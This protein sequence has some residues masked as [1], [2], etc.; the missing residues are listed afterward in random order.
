M[1][2]MN[3]KEWAHTPTMMLE[4]PNRRTPYQRGEDDGLAGKPG[5]AFPRADSDWSERLYN[6]GWEA[7]ISKRLE[8]QRAASTG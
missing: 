6:R 1:A 5:P 4:P 8:K 3:D 7:G 2:D